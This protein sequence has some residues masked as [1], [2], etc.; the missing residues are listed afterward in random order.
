[1]ERRLRDGPRHGEHWVRIVMNQAI[2]SFLTGLGPG[3]LSAIEISGRGR[4]PLGWR[5]FRSTEYPAFD[6]L[7]PTQIGTYDVVLCEQVLEHVPDPWK[8]MRTLFELCNPGGHVVVGTPFMLRLHREPMDYW[9]FSP[10]GLREMATAAGF[11]SITL[12]SWGNGWCTFANR[13]RW[14]VYR[15]MHRMLQRWA[16]RDEPDNPQ[17]VWLFGQRP[18][19]TDPNAVA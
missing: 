11:E 13:R 2:E 7:H 15:P 10:D 5:S 4:E 18:L 6:L 9:R 19:S 17:V 16:L 14:V 12:G 3:E 1:M 8:A